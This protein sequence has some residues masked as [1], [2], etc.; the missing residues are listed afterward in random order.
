MKRRR[1]MSRKKKKKKK[2]IH[3]R[4]NFVCFV[5]LSSRGRWGTGKGKV[6]RHPCIALETLDSHFTFTPW[7]LPRGSGASSSG[8]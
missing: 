5:V 2:R 6:K 1:M 8:S 4:R 3:S 7:S